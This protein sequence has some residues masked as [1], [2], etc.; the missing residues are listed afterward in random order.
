MCTI[1]DSFINYYK[2]CKSA[3]SLNGGV[4][5]GRNHKLFDEENLSTW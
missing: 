3:I 2:A 1:T 4:M 5:V